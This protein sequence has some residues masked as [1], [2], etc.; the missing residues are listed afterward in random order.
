M[1]YAKQ[2]KLALFAAN[3]QAIKKEF[4]WQD[5]MTKR[6]AALLYAL[7][8]KTV[9]CSAVRECHNLIKSNTGAFSAFRGNM[10]LCIA[11]MLSLCENREEQFSNTLFVYSLLKSEKLRASDYLA[12][13]AY[14]IAANAPKERHSQAVDS[15]R[16]F[17]AGMKTKHWFHTG[18]DDY[19]YAAMLGL[20]GINADTG[21][22]RI[23]KL[24][25]RLKPEFWSGNSVQ[26]LSQILVLGN[27][28]DEAV[29]HILS[30]RDTLR[31]KKIRLDKMY[32]LPALGV[33]ALLPVEGDVL[34]QDILEAQTSLR[35]QKGFGAFSVT[36]QELLLYAAAIISSSYAEN[37]DNSL[38]TA[39]VS[40]SIASIII[41]QQTAIIAAAASS[42]AAATAASS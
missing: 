36:S 17:Y 41:A 42:G 29:Q 30:L 38:I 9:D 4:T 39:S 32:T 31:S 5:A 25:K 12:V 14:Q 37:T 28:S 27:K 11:A 16:A 1:K 22:E 6:L 3:A 18:K 33:L 34:A 35:A 26:A 24:Y 10:S 21:A 13:A 2:E 40:T 7:E 15:T 8:S 20:S 23:E 19:I